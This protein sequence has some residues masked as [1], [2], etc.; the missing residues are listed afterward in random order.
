VSTGGQPKAGSG[1]SRRTHK[2]QKYFAELF[3][4]EVP[5]N[6]GF[7]YLSTGE[8]ETELAADG[9]KAIEYSKFAERLELELLKYYNSADTAFWQTLLIQPIL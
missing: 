6:I 5:K 1:T 7:D 9:L 2:I 3:D 8:E 4:S